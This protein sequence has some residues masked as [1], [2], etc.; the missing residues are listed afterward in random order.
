MKD[1]WKDIALHSIL[2]IICLELCVELGRHIH[3]ERI[4]SLNKNKQEQKSPYCKLHEV[5]MLRLSTS[6]H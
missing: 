2:D 4:C 5:Y 3:S 1:M 6:I